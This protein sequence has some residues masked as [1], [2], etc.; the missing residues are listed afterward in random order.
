MAKVAAD[1]MVA[2]RMIH[3]FAAATCKMAKVA[4]EEQGLPIAPQHV[5]RQPAKW[6]RL[7][8]CCPPCDAP[9]ARVPRQPAKWL[10]LRRAKTAFFRAVGPLPR[11]PAKWLR[12][13]R[14]ADGTWIVFG[15]PCGN[16]RNGKG[17]VGTVRTAKRYG[18]LTLRT[19]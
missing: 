6:L 17:C 11:Q 1:G 18:S 16:L 19:F 8:R 9:P 3:T 14:L 7:R 15:V 12:L 2:P 10:R 13:R 4:A 5:P